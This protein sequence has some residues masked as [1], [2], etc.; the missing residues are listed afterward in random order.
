MF[1]IKTKVTAFFLSFIVLFFGNIVLITGILKDRS[2]DENKRIAGDKASLQTSVYSQEPS[3]KSSEIYSFAEELPPD[4]TQD[5]IVPHADINDADELLP[6]DSLDDYEDESYPAGYYV[7][8]E[9]MPA[10][11][12]KLTAFEGQ[13]AFYRISDSIKEEYY[14]ITD[15]DVFNTITYILV[16]EGEYL[17]LIDASASPLEKAESSSALQLENS[18][19]KYL[20]GKD[21]PA[22]TYTVIPDEKSGYV[23]I[24]A[25]P[26]KSVSD[27]IF[28]RIIHERIQITLEEGQYIKLSSARLEPVE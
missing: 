14:S 10:G 12:Y 7:I 18:N 26:I 13:A 22:D 23:E 6:G 15:N 16:E 17:N 28:S 25:S 21:L 19:G 9:D 1:N 24:A 8:G 5:S 27:I 11:I 2:A 3:D 4:S 20:V